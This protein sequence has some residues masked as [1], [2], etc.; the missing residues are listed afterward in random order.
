MAKNWD[1]ESTTYLKRYAATRTLAEIAERYETEESDVE[2]RLLELKLSS[3]DGRGYQAPFVDPSIS[4]FEAGL[5]AFHKGNHATARKKFEAVIEK[6]EQLELTARARLYVQACVEAEEGDGG[7][8][9]DPFLEA[10]MLKNSGDLEAALEMCRRGGREG[11]DERFA[12]LAAA[13]VALTGEPEDA[14]AQLRKAIE[15]NDENRIHAY[16]D[17]DFDSLR[18]VE[19]FTDLYKTEEA[20]TEVEAEAEAVVVE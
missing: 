16:H 18:E 11:K 8:P 17:S 15:M 4:D 12:Y 7:A 3:K 14:M 20:E 1:K 13:I 9:D 5:E 19:E 2:Q 6:S 10:V